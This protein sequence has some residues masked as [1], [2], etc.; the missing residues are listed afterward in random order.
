MLREITI[1]DIASMETNQSSSEDG[2]YIFAD[3]SVL[4]LPP[5]RRVALKYTELK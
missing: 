2:T 5:H 3:A 4:A 1:S